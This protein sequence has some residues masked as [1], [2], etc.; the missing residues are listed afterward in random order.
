MSCNGPHL[1]KEPDEE[2]SQ[3]KLPKSSSRYCHS[4]EIRMNTTAN[5]ITI[6]QA[7]NR[8]PKI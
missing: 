4:N 6:F 5:Y 7:F 3:I 2:Q 1:E 8:N